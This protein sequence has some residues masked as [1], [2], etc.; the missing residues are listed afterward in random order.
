MNERPKRVRNASTELLIAAQY[1]RENPT[2]A[3]ACLW[4]AI[5]HKKLDGLRFRSQ[6]PVETFIFDF[7]C[8]AYK[9]IIEVDGSI[10]DNPDTQEHDQLR[11]E[12]VEAHGYNVLRLRNDEILTNLPATLQKIQNHIAALTP[13][14]NN[15]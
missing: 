13:S 1:H 5:R 14:E 3:E 9:L 15:E 4:E 8:P 11:D 2:P 12:W 6:H 10:H 7:Y